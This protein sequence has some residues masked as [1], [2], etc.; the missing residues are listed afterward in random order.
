METNIENI[1]MPN[2]KD[3]YISNI[4]PEIIEKYTTQLKS[5]IK[6]KII[7]V[8]KTKLKLLK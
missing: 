7:K 2:G 8:A 1:K 4:N 6:S 5:I 3:E